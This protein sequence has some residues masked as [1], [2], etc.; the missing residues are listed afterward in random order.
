MFSDKK[1][2]KLTSKMERNLIGE[3]TNFVGDIVSKGDFRIDG[4]IEGTIKTEGR[5]IIGKNGVVKGNVYCSNA[6]VE[7][8]F[9]GELDVKSILIL[10]STARVSGKV[11]VGKLMVEPGAIFNTTCTMKGA[12]KELNNNEQNREKEQKKIKAS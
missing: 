6:D 5:V 2:K 3:G 8:I 9:S 7:G 11:V 1:N 4:T 12:V 10:K